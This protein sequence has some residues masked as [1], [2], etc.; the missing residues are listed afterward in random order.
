MQVSTLLIRYIDT[1]IK[2]SITAQ[3]LVSNM[4]NGKIVPPVGATAQT[5]KTK[6]IQSLEDALSLL[7]IVTVENEVLATDSLPQDKKVLIRLA[8]AVVAEAKNSEKVQLANGRIIIPKETFKGLLEKSV[9]PP[10]LDENA[11]STKLVGSTQEQSSGKQPKPQMLS[12]RAETMPMFAPPPPIFKKRDRVKNNTSQ[13]ASSSAVSSESRDDDLPMLSCAEAYCILVDIV[14]P[15]G[16]KYV[17][18]VQNSFDGSKEQKGELEKGI[19]SFWKDYGHNISVSAKLCNFVIQPRFIVGNAVNAEV[20][21][22]LV[23]VYISQSTSE[24]LASGMIKQFNDSV[25]ITPKT[26]KI[27]INVVDSGA[28]QFIR[29]LSIYA[30]PSQVKNAQANHQNN[31]FAPQPV[32]A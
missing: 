3:A 27:T 19:S 23:M 2:M 5:I 21:K 26:G 30:R 17:L 1:E 4:P 24:K 8:R 31:S 32:P 16:G 7:K 22:K 12:P 28:V 29:N 25:S 13:S 18:Q 20:S 10:T 6:Q 14:P 9:E 15:G 11:A